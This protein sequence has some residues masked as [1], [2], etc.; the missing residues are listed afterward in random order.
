MNWLK[1]AKIKIEVGDRGGEGTTLHNIGM[2]F[3]AQRN[4]HAG[5]AC[6]LL[7]KRLYEQVESSLDVD[8]E[9]GV[10]NSLRSSLGEKQFSELLKNVEP[11]AQSIIDDVLHDLS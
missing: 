10:L 5:L 4:I 6:I 9:V 8:H 3:F 1:Q 2:I 11:Q 7:A